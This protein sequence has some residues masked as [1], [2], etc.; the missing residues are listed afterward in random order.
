[1]VVA[2]VHPGELVVSRTIVESVAG[3]NDAVKL[4][5]RETQIGFW[6][7]TV[8]LRRAWRS[9]LRGYQSDNILKE[10]VVQTVCM[11]PFRA[12]PCIAPVSSVQLLK[13][14]IVQIVDASGIEV[15]EFCI[16][17]AGP[18]C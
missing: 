17:A 8:G 2:L 4:R 18:S 15:V 5:V 1:M 3:R 10:K 7:L 6:Q 16:G 14:T 12:H 13:I 11:L 9:E